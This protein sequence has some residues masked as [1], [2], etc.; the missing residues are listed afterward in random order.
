MFASR[1]M[2]AFNIMNGILAAQAERLRIEDM[3]SRMPPPGG[4]I[5]LSLPGFDFEPET[6]E[7]KLI[8]TLAESLARDPSLAGKTMTVKEVYEAA[9]QSRFGEFRRT[10][11]RAAITLLDEQK[12][13]DVVDRKKGHGGIAWGSTIRLR[14]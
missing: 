10:L 9:W 8:R 12:R 3:A 2:L 4:P 1:N 11:Y 14:A 5:A 7:Q 6:D 13:V